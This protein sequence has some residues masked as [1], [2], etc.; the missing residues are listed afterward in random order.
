MHYRYLVTDYDDCA[1]SA[2][3]LRGDNLSQSIINMALTGRYNGFYGCTH[4][5]YSSYHVLERMFATANR[6]SAGFYQTPYKQNFAT[7]KITENFAAATHLPNMAVS[8]LD[9]LVYKKCGRGYALVLKPYEVSKQ[10]PS[11]PYLSGLHIAKELTSKNAQLTIIA[12]H[13]AAEHPDAEIVLDYVDDKASL[14]H[15]AINASMSADWPKNVFLNI[16]HYA[17][18][19]VTAIYEPERFFEAMES[20]EGEDALLDASERLDD[21]KGISARSPLQVNSLFADM[22]RASVNVDFV[23][24]TPVLTQSTSI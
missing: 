24:D 2:A 21:K 11:T 7:Y 9:D 8:T 14:C 16:Y 15:E 10:L 22:L 5:A 23:A 6:W 12:K 18:R 20:W 3:S 1:Y 19:K 13:A 17:N 4:R